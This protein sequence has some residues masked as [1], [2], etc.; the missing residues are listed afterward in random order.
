MPTMWSQH[1]SHTIPKRQP[2]SAHA[3]EASLVASPW[4]K[5]MALEHAAE[6]CE[7]GRIRLSNLY[8]YRRAENLATGIKDLK[9][10]EYSYNVFVTY[11]EHFDPISGQHDIFHDCRFMGSE[12]IDD[13]YVFCASNRND[14]AI[15]REFSSYDATVEISNPQ[16]F[17]TAITETL[18]AQ[19]LKPSSPVV[20]QCIYLDFPVKEPLFLDGAYPA[21][22]KQREFERQAEVRVLW[23]TTA[24]PQH[25]FIKD[26]RI[27]RACRLLRRPRREQ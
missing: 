25:L 17:I 11:G 14:E 16:L 6:M 19:N 21:F 18:A 4:Y 9:D 7:V 12:Y 27:V 2:L 1:T 24:P 26:E 8:Y 3:S 10:G 20:N 22:V 13:A 23:E 5:Y 15:Q